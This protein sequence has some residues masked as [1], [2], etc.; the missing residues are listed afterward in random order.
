MEAEL[1]EQ[2]GAN[3]ESVAAMEVPGFAGGDFV[4]DN[5]GTENGSK[6]GGI[7]VERVIEELPG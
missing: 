3:A 7:I 2:G 1:V 6:R 4:M 5:D